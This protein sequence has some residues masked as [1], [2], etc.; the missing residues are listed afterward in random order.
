MFSPLQLRHVKAMAITYNCLFLW[1]Y[2]F[3]KWGFLF[4][5]I[6]GI[7]GHN[8]RAGF[9]ADVPFIQFLDRWIM[10]FSDPLFS[11]VTF[12]HG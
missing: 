11:D 8:C 6:T 9:P 7:S 5:L 1:D 3:Y 12:P 4:V 2:T 10:Q